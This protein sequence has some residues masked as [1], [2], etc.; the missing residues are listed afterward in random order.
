MSA[1]L[2]DLPLPE[3]PH[4]LGDRPTF[5]APEG[6]DDHASFAFG[7][8]LYHAGCLWEAHEVWEGLWRGRERG[9]R[10]AH[11]LRGLI[12]AAAAGLKARAGRTR[13]VASLVAKAQVEL[14]AAGARIEL[15]D[16]RVELGG[17]AAA[18]ERWESG[19]RTRKRTG[20]NSAPAPISVCL[21]RPS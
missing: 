17:F 21:A 3:R 13:G 16:W 19:G 8:D 12:Q 10:E 7:V 20:S 1:R 14:A 11:A 6:L 4:R 2:S 15:A 5:E 9:S 18:L